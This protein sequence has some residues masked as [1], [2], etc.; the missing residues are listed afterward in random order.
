MSAQDLSRRLFLVC[1]AASPAFLSTRPAFA[2]DKVK[3]GK[4]ITS[5]FPFAGLE[6]A[7][8]QG[9]WAA[10]GIDTEII[11][12]AGDGRMQQ[13][14]A[15][16]AL[17]FGVGSGPGMGYATKGVPAHAIAA[18][19]YEPRNMSIVVTD[20]SPV[21]KIDDLKGMKIGVTT[22]GSLTDWLARQLAQSKGW[23]A[24]GVEVVPMGDM[25]A[26]L[27]AMRSGDLQASVN[28][29]EESLQL[30]EQGGG[31]MLTTFG[32]AVPDFL[33]HV[34]Y[35]SDAVIQKQPDLVRRFLRAWFRT[36]AFMRDHRTE[37][38][39]S[40]AKTMNVSEKV[41]DMAYD[42]ELKMLSFDGAFPPKALE[43]I[44]GSLKQLGITDT[45]PALKAM[46]DP[47]FV[48]VKL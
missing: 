23:G 48:P 42:D 40:V 10:E 18:I 44:R 7:Q 5:S 2:A 37:T 28:S 9:I 25:R 39:Q 11:A 17:D 29:I 13:A 8:Q 35:A 27:A 41:V 3:V 26:R 47:Q 20:N 15:A 36:A 46:Y 31:K 21:K 24:D 30:Q 12:F 22:A 19:A 1:A 45:E 4:A 34:V 33:T 16:G 32:D 6:L 14:F 38:V 43:V